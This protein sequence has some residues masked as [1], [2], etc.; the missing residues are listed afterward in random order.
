[1]AQKS[2][3]NTR[4][5]VHPEQYTPN[6]EL[7]SKCILRIFGKL[8]N[9]P[10]EFV[11]QLQTGEIITINGSRFDDVAIDRLH[12]IHAQRLSDRAVVKIK[13]RYRMD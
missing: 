1:M 9:K 11:I 3:H 4:K 2:P 8:L 5:R 13:Q 7:K 6:G 10:S 12:K